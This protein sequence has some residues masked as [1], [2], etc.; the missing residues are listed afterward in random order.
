MKKRLAVLLCAAAVVGSSLLYAVPARKV[1]KQVVQPDGS[2]LRIQLCG[3]EFFRYYQTADGV[4]LVEVDGGFYYASLKGISLKQTSRLPAHELAQRSSK[5]LLLSDSLKMQFGLQM[6]QA[7]R[8]RKDR[9]ADKC[10]RSPDAARN[11]G[12]QNLPNPMIGKKKGLVVLVNF[13]DVKMKTP[14]AHATFHRMMNEEGYSDHGQHGSVRDYFLSQSYG[15]FDFSFDVAGPVTLPNTMAYYGKNIQGFDIRP[16]E[17]VLDACMQIQ[18]QVNFADY[19]WDGDGE[20]EQIFVIYAG[21]A[22]SNGAPANTIWPHQSYVQNRDGSDLVIDGT[23]IG[24]YACSSELT[25]VSGDVVAGIGTMCHEFSH[26]FGIPDFYDINGVNFGMDVWSL[27]DYGCYNDNGNTP[28]GYTSYERMMCGWLQPTLLNDT[29]AVRDMPCL[30]EAPV[31]YAIQ[32]EA[33]KSE[34][35][36]LENRQQTGW[37]RYLP[38]HGMLVLHVDYDEKAWDMNMVN[39]NANRLRMSYIAADNARNANTLEFDLFPGL[40]GVSCLTDFSKP[41]AALN[42]NNPQGIKRMSKP[43]YNIKEQDGLIGFDFLK[44]TAVGISEV[45]FEKAEP[46]VWNVYHP[47]GSLAGKMSAAQIQYLLK[48]GIYLLRSGS[49]TRKVMIR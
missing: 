45:L 18:N 30:S 20:A 40:R 15:Q 37:D 4:P 49:E 17:M 28:V 41:A 34:Y 6:P 26:C 31:A 14:H 46:F 13:K 23:I 10:R 1:W 39:T 29:A 2:E 27:M 32:N 25:G 48:P 22:E 9:N 11:F 19:D 24:K 42:T 33:N 8:I 36:L 44:D 21:Y 3:D 16:G 47:D 38:S 43:I 35:Y 5:E 7:Y 12:G